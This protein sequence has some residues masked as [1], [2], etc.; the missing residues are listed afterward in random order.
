M[1]AAFERRALQV[2]LAALS[3]I[4]VGSGLAGIIGG[5]SAA[6]G[7]RGQSA[8]ASLDNEYRFLNVY[9][10]AVAPML[11]RMLPNIESEQRRF[12]LLAGTVAASG[13]ARSLAWRRT[14]RPHPV[15]VGATALE[16]IGMPVV[17]A[18]QARIAR[19]TS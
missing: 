16:L 6:T 19:R 1:D 12:R 11:W 14:G 7:N 15:F 18:W 10:L 8:T 4:P 5:P 9:W 2:I 3:A 13:L 17:I